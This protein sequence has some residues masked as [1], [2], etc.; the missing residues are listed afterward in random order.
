M[1]AGSVIAY[2]PG[3]EAFGDAFYLEDMILITEDGSEVLSAGLPYEAE[4][5]EALM[6]G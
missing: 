5:I 4:Q 1:E 2:E 6:G 3:F